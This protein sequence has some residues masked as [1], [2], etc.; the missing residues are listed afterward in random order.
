MLLGTW[1]TWDSLSLYNLSWCLP[2]ASLHVALTAM[3]GLEEG[4]E[5][6]FNDGVKEAPLYFVFS[7]VVGRG[8]HS[9]VN[10]SLNE[11]CRV[12]MFGFHFYYLPWWK[13]W[14]TICFC[15]REDVHRSKM[16]EANSKGEQNGLQ[17][18]STASKVRQPSWDSIGATS[19]IFIYNKTYISS[20][21]CLSRSAWISVCSH[22]STVPQEAGGG[23][24]Y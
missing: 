4:G 24:H 1:D 13:A 12:K 20:L 9:S 15:L 21:I 17:R 2:S 8:I 5:S 23:A 11:D 3:K 22:S 19:I 7:P 6:P 16:I 10:Q 18:K 14:H